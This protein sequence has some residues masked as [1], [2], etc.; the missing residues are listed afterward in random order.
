MK[1]IGSP[2]DS[3]KHYSKRENYYKDIV[4]NLSSVIDNTKLGG[5]KKAIER[6]HSKGKLTARERV[7]L[8]IF[9]N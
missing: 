3:L 6:Q 9:L 2:K 5:G 8:L 7:S 1:I 4:D